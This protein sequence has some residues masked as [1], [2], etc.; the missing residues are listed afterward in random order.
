MTE[1]EVMPEGL[2]VVIFLKEAEENGYKMDEK[3][4][5]ILHNI[6]IRCY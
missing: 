3:S 2:E 5:E 4:K 6:G 1:I